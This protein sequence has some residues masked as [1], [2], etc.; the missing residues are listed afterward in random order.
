MH[1]G[2]PEYR[3]CE[4]NVIIAHS[5]TAEC[6]LALYASVPTDYLDKNK[7]ETSIALAR[8]KA[9]VS[10]RKGTIFINPGERPVNNPSTCIKSLQLIIIQV[11]RVVRALISSLKGDLFS[12]E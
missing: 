10:P 2:R 1:P 5:Y 6:Y 9:T 4:N 3:L 11:D 12:L 7:G 8:Y